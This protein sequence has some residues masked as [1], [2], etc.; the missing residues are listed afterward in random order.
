MIGIGVI[1]KDH[2][3]SIVVALSK[4]LPFPLD[5]LEVEAKAMDE[6]IVFEWDIGVRDVIFESDSTLVCHAMENPTDAPVYISTVVLGFC[7][8]LPVF[9]TFQSSHMRRQGNRPA[10]T[11]A[12]FAKN[13]DS[14]VTWMEKCPPFLT[15]LVSQDAI[16]YF[17]I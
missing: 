6:A 10:H 1:I 9:C 7:T 4:C 2:L 17:A 14:F 16:Y 3:G 11:L 8:R 12:T 15:S 5:P 13:I